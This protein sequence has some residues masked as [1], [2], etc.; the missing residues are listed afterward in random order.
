MPSHME[1]REPDD[2][3]AKRV[4]RRAEWS[5]ALEAR[6]EPRKARKGTFCLIRRGSL[7]QSN[8]RTETAISWR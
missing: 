6:E 8:F 7:P 4:S 5:E 3:K 1:M 2:M